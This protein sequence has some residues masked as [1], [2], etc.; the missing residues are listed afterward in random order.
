MKNIRVR[1]YSLQDY[2]RDAKGLINLLG[3]EIP[4][5]KELQDTGKA[6]L[7]DPRHA[8]KWSILARK[9]K[10]GLLLLWLY[11]VAEK[12]QLDMTIVFAQRLLE[13]W[14]GCS[15]SNKTLIQAFGQ[16]NRDAH[17]KSESWGQLNSL[18]DQYQE[19]VKNS[20]ERDKKRRLSIKENH[21][22]RLKAEKIIG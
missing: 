9:R 10:A 1:P 2:S 6:V 4:K 17:S 16:R 15:I 19:K 7:L 11:F 12:H 18:V 13:A 21:W 22:E 8:A 20:L 14:V 5:L 3:Q